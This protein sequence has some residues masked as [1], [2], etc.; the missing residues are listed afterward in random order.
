M[1]T[2][3]SQAKWHALFPVQEEDRQEHW[4]II[5]K[6]PYRT[7]R[8]TKLQAFQF[9]LLH[10]IIPCNKYLSNIRILQDDSCPNCGDQDNLQHFFLLC[11][12]VQEFWSKIVDW[13]RD[14]AD[15]ILSISLQEILFGIPI[16]SQSDRASNFLYIFG[17]FF[18]YRQRLFHGSQ[19]NLLHFLMELRSKLKIEK[20]ILAREGK[21]GKFKVW[22]RIFNALG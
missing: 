14:N 16:I 11:P 13:L 12:L 7:T 15:F 8:E 19:L 18:V 22:N 9:R 1:P 4:S 10:R 17:K 6:L 3:S 5:Y 21:S 2:V 20:F